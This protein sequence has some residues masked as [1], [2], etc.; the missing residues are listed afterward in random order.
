[1]VYNEFEALSNWYLDDTAVRDDKE[2]MWW[3][4]AVTASNEELQNE[5]FDVMFQIGSKEQYDIYQG[6]GVMWDLE[7]LINGTVTA[8]QFQ[9][10]YKQEI[11]AALDAYFKK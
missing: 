6:L 5:N 9:E 11:Q 8:A 7:S 1:L 3:W 10:T 4:Y 2:T